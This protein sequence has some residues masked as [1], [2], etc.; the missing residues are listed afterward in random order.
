[1][2]APSYNR[3]A[4]KSSALYCISLL[5]LTLV[6]RIEGAQPS[7]TPAVYGVPVQNLVF[8]KQQIAKGDASVAG[9]YANLITRANA[10]LTAKTTSVMDKSAVAASGNKHDYFSYGPYW[11]P[12][13]T[14]P[15][16]QR[17]I[18]RDGYVNPDSRNGTDSVAFA[19][20]CSNVETLALAYY[21]TEKEAYAEKAASLVRVWFLDTATAMNP[22]VNYGQ[23]VPGISN[24]RFE[25]LIE[26]RHL[27]RITDALALIDN[28][29]SWRPQ[30]KAAFKTWLSNYYDWLLHNRLK[31]DDTSTENNHLTWR[32]VQIVQFALVLGR[33]NE[34]RQFL[35]QEF[36]HL[37]AVQIKRNGEQPKELVRTNSL[38]YSVFN[39]EALFRLATL[40][41]YLGVD[42][43]SIV[44]NR[45]ATLSVVFDVL[46]SYVD[47]AR[48]WPV[49]EA[50]LTDRSRLLPLLAQAYQH[51]KATKYRNLLLQ[52]NGNGD[53]SWSLWWA[54]AIS[55][56]S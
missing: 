21:F 33:E 5:C 26:M 31:A 11:W 49:K 15:Q 6:A 41:D 13:P 22:Q 34:A 24:G 2:K 28:S 20:L 23:A 17:Y 25:G 18:K 54:P 3:P 32:D 1:M 45:G 43:W 42:C 36:E 9:A 52:Y 12:D 19:K 53:T 7:V 46:S 40:G 14:D 38:G 56:T 35:K 37:L 30:D 44:S 48:P 50:S 10:A 27:T 51:T 39:V 4:A 47:P 55:T 8:A 16:H 29:A